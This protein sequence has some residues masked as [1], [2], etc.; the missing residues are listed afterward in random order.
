VLSVIGDTPVSCVFV[1]VLVRVVVGSVV[2]AVGVPGAAES[3]GADGLIVNV[4]KVVSILVLSGVVLIESKSTTLFWGS[5][6]LQLVVELVYLSVDRRI[7]RLRCFCVAVL[8]ESSRV[9]VF[10]QSDSVIEHLG[11]PSVELSSV[12]SV[13]P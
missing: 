10:V 13:D 6:W 1:S 2:G 3:D 7:D 5:L 4:G 12:V 9:S 11:E 8:F